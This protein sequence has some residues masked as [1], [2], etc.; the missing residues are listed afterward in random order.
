M[1]IRFYKDNNTGEVFFSVSGQIPEGYEE[2][3]ANTT[4][5]AVEKHV[6][7]ITIEGNRAH[8]EVGST[9]HP[10]SEAHHISFIVLVTDSRAELA[11]LDPT[12]SPTA[13][14]VL[15][16]NEKVL[17]AYEYCNLHGLWIKENN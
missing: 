15:A 1:N 7:V 3:R 16:E 17:A 4:D 6:P 11:N 8:V 14:F 9:L 2:L 12:G 10:M 5:A 13:D